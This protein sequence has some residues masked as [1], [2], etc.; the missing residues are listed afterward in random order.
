MCGKEIE[1]KSEERGVQLQRQQSDYEHQLDK[2]QKR[3]EDLEETIS[4]HRTEITTSE[5]ECQEE[6]ISVV[7]DLKSTRNILEDWK[8]KVDELT[9][10]NEVL[11]LQLEELTT[12][13]A[14]LSTLLEELKSLNA[15]LSN[16]MEEAEAS[17]E[18]LSCQL[19]EYQIEK[20]GAYTG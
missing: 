3:L 8:K 5:R 16:R 14:E 2:S 13:N 12:S 15:D 4:N 7:K 1:K 10:T 11:S 9:A 17:N 18:H 19:V 6:R 20:N